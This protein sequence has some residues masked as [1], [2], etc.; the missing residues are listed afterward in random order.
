MDNC[1]YCDE[2]ICAGCGGSGVHPLAGRG[3]PADRDYVS[4][5][6]V[7]S[8]CQGSG[9]CSADPSHARKVP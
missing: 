2:G 8:W 4:V 5:A 3:S 9:V 1:A 7:C 6:E